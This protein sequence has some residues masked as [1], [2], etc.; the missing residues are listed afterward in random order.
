MALIIGTLDDDLLIGTPEDDTILGLAGRDTI[1]GQAGDDFLSG[2]EDND[3]IFGGPGRDTAFGGMDDDFVDGGPDND[4]LFGDLGDDTIIGDIGGE[5]PV[6]NLLERDE[7]FGGQGNDLL[8]GGLGADLIYAG[9]GNDVVFGGKDD[10]LINGDL[11][12]DTL[13]GDQGS[14]TIYGGQLGYDRTVLD[15]NDSILGGA[16]DDWLFGG[17]GADT[18]LGGDGQDILFGGQENDSLLG[19]NGNDVLFGDL[20]SDT[21]H[22]EEGCDIFVIGLRNDVTTGLTTGGP[23]IADADWFQDFDPAFDLIGLVGGLTFSQLNIF[24]GTDEYAGHTIIQETVNGEYLAILRG[25]ESS[26]ITQSNFT[27]FTDP[28]TNE[29]QF[30]SDNFLVGEGDGQATIT[31]TRD[32]DVSA[33]ASATVIVTGGSATSPDDY[34]GVPVAVSFGAGQTITTITIPIVDDVLLEGDETVDLR[35]IDP[36]SGVKFKGQSATVLSILDNDTPAPTPLPTPA[37]TPEPTPTPTPDPPLP[38]DPTV[39]LAVMPD[40]VVEDSGDTLMFTFTRDDSQN[41]PLT[42]SLTV[43]FTIGGNALFTPDYSQL[44]ADNFTGTVGTI[45]F[46]PG[47]NTV[48]ITITPVQE[49][50]VEPNETVELTLA[51]GP[52]IIGTPGAVI[53]T[54]IDDD[55]TFFQ[56]SL[57]NYTVVEGSST[58]VDFATP[59]PGLTVNRLGDATGTATVVI[60]FTDTD[61]IGSDTALAGVDYRNTPITVFFADG[62]TSVMIT[63]GLIVP[64][65]LTEPVGG[66]VPGSE[67]FNISLANPSIGSVGGQS[68]AT[69]EIIDDDDTNFVFSLANYTVVEGSNTTVDFA[70]SIPDLVVNRLGSA[71]GTA[72]VL[73]Q[74]TDGDAIGSDTALAGVDYKNTPILL[75]FADGQTSVN[76]TDA[77]IIPDLL[78]EPPGATAPGSEFFNLSLANPTQGFLGGQS[79]AMV[80]IIDDDVPPIANPDNVIMQ[81]GATATI[82]IALLLANDVPNTGIQFLSADPQSANAIPVTFDDNGTPADPSDDVLIYVAGA[83][84]GTDSFNYTITDGVNT[85]SAAV[86]ISIVDAAGSLVGTDGNDLLIGDD[87]SGLIVGGPGSDIIYGGGE[88]DN[89]AGGPGAD[90]FLYLDPSE[91]VLDFITP[92]IAHDIILDFSLSDPDLIA[93]TFD[94]NLANFMVL[95]ISGGLGEIFE[96][97]GV[98]S[99]EFYIQVNVP[100]GGATPAD[101]LNRIQVGPFP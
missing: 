59:V 5:N 74:F 4:T 18:V 67:F 35:L 97:T 36:S 39:T 65:L 69:V 48:K 80:E 82:S 1:E 81:V 31:L 22:G 34:S 83:M 61:A 66:T 88:G 27:A 54:I 98:T 86:N 21:L 13:S 50:L 100:D 53:G 85:A 38:L 3:T 19:G 51:P 26:E 33:S 32:G 45:T 8:F 9:K 71:I 79:T 49:L 29:I 44:G 24:P 42:S 93:I 75:F 40:D 43:N 99:P 72:T 73:L 96:I 87:Q 47:Q 90:V 14:D 46:P 56:F 20:G 77:L 78:T 16:G 52:Y 57:A 76:I 101:I 91:S 64:D 58:V 15:G 28:I 41:I 94:N 25:V 17:R 10:D 63:D 68:T 7:I 70:T 55:N 84:S 62:Q 37:P 12:D 11:G 6:G 92:I 23:I 89:L 2:Y 30:S 95:D 60:Q